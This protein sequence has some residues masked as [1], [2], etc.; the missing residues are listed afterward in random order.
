MSIS[1]GDTVTTI[2]ISRDKAGRLIHLW[3]HGIFEVLALYS[4]V[5]GPG[6]YGA[7]MDKTTGTYIP[8]AYFLNP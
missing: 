8:V 4:S 5:S 3:I 7:V 6:Y 1:I 2:Q